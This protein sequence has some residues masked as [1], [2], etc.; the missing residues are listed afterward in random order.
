MNQQLILEG[1]RLTL[2]M[3]R[4]VEEPD[5]R[6]A[7]ISIAAKELVD[8]HPVVFDFLSAA[9]LAKYPIGKLPWIYSKALAVAADYLLTT[10]P[11]WPIHLAV[12]EHLFELARAYIED[13]VRISNGMGRRSS[14]NPFT[15]SL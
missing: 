3:I 4:H 15:D 9:V 10:S 12:N 14:R 6:F 11:G 7:I 13:A 1:L 8:A 5:E 2:T